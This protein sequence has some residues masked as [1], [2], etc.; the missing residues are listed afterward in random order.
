MGSTMRI[1]ITPQ[2]LSSSGTFTDIAIRMKL[3]HLQGTE[4]RPAAVLN[5]DW[6]RTVAYSEDAGE[7]ALDTHA[8][9]FGDINIWVI[10]KARPVE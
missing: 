3:P 2:G 4:A 10:P 7:W 8:M 5:E 1:D 6:N 9:C